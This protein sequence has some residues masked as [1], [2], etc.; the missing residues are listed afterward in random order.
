MT[1]PP[2]PPPKGGSKP[3]DWGEMGQKLKGAQGPNRTLLIAGLLFFVDSFLPWYG[4]RFSVLGRGIGANFSGWNS[5]GLAVIAILLGIAATALA[6]VEVTG[7][8]DASKMP[9]G[10]VSLALAGGAFVFTV[11][12][13]VTQVHITKYGLY[14]GIVLSGVMAYAAYQKFQATQS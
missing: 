4:F 3:P 9:T 1:Q 8:V 2:P 11:L 5:G 7:A 12:R 13:L 6:V 14:F 10:T